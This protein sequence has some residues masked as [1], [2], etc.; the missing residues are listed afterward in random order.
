MSIELVKHFFQAAKVIC[1][2]AQNAL[3]DSFEIFLNAIRE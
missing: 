3:Y 2:F 1:I